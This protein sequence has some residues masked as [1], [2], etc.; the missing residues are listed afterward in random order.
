M[1]GLKTDLICEVADKQINAK[2]LKNGVPITDN[3]DI[4]IESCDGIHKLCIKQTDK[5]SEGQYQINFG[6]KNS[7]AHLKV[8]GKSR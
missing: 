3:S 4:S 2:W 7:T 1:E 6:N 8:T 5:N